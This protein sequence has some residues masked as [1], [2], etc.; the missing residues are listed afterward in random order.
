MIVLLV[1]EILTLNTMHFQ[2]SENWSLATKN[3][4]ERS[5]TVKGLTPN[6]EYYYRVCA[7]NDA[8]RSPFA[9]LDE[10]VL[11]RDP[12]GNFE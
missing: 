4:R 11:A 3:H 5:Y 8:G 12:L 6:A 7:V 1:T 9:Q 2:G 10:P